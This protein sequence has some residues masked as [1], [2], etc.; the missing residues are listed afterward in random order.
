MRNWI[1]KY[2]PKHEFYAEP[3]CG[4][5]SILLGKAPAPKGELINDL[6]SEIINLF[7]VMQNSDQQKELIQKLEWT[8]YAVSEF[9]LS[10]QKSDDPV[11]SARRMIVRSFFGIETSGVKG[12]STGFRMSGVNLSRLGRDGKP[13]FR[14]CARDW[15]NWKDAF[16]QIIER[17]KKVM[18]FEM[19]AFQFLDVVNDPGCLVY[20]DPPYHPETRSK[21][22]S[23]T[24][25][26]HE[27][28]HENHVELINKILTLKSMV[29]LS[30]YKQ[31]H[32]KPLED[33]GWKRV[34]KQ[35]RANMSHRHRTECLWIS[36]NAAKRTEK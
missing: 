14:N 12:S 26:I 25:Y 22:H 7:R 23:G 34:Q 29:I 35:S 4:A 5:A 27:L 19:D 21:G 18:I 1:I 28:S 10:R 24:R 33:A 8:P 15:G 30:G 9:K 6:N 31:N 36:P 32:Y 11:E 2:F 17:L 16:P 20:I 13:T 3:F